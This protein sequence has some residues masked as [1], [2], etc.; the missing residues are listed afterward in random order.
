[1]QRCALKPRNACNGWPDPHHFPNMYLS[2]EVEGRSGTEE[3][4][5]Q[6]LGKVREC[7]KL[8]PVIIS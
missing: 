6:E 1:M 3:A 2:Y 4:M 7:V 8:S 5:K